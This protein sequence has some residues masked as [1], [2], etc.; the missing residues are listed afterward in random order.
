MTHRAPAETLP[1]CGQGKTSLQ[2][3]LRWA[4]DVVGAEIESAESLRADHSPW[5]LR[6]HAR[7][8][9]VVLRIIQPGWINAQP[10]RTNAAALQVAEQHG[11][12]AP[13]LIAVDPDGDRAGT[14]ATLE[15]VLSGSS[16]LPPR[17]SPDRLRAFGA[18][19]ARVHAIRL[20]RQDGLPFLTR[21]TQEDRAME[22][23]WAAL[24]HA[25]PENAK[26]DVIQTLCE[27]TGWPTERAHR[28][29][30]GPPA[31]ALLL[32]ADERIRA[33][34]RPDQHSVFLHGDVWGGNSL[35]DG[36]M[37]LALIDWKDAGVGD[38]GVDLGNLRLQMAM[39]YGMDAPPYVLEGWE[40]AAGRTA[41]DVA[42]WDTVAALNTPTVL[43][44]WPGFDDHGAP[45]DA[46]AVTERRDAFLRAA[47]SALSSR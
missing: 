31:T 29:V 2:R 22:R 12:P 40:R 28:A 38:P 8:S 26:P 6:F 3:A 37:C 43:H 10:I 20:E 44:G 33:T 15:T 21:T 19:I 32:L 9:D 23:R 16:A 24:Y 39:Q 17:V 7:D 30:D 36:D 42:Y 4:A 1:E 25:S 45:L 41:T 18:A 11:L 5:R 27:L 34:P 13:R 46:T 47:V 14:P 35:W